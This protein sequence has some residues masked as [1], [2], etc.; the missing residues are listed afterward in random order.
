MM[1]SPSFTS[2]AQ[3]SVSSHDIRSISKVFTDCYGIGPWL[4]AVFGDDGSGRGNYITCDG[5]VLDG[6]PI[7]VYSILGGTC[8]LTSLELELLQPL[9]GKSVFSQYLDLRGGMPGFQHLCADDG[10]G[11]NQTRALLDSLGYR[12]EQ[13]CRIDSIELCVMRD[14]A[15]LLGCRLELHQRGESF[16][17][18]QIEP[19]FYPAGNTMSG[20]PTPIFSDCTGVTFVVKEIMDVLSV[21]QDAMHLGQ[22]TVEETHYSWLNHSYPVRK[23]VCSGMNIQLELLQPLSHD[24]FLSNHLNRWGPNALSLSMAAC[25]PR[26]EVYRRMK[27][28]SCGKQVRLSF[29]GCDRI[30][31]NHLELMGLY[32]EI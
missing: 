26:Q 19:E 15:P 16:R 31:C 2:F 3:V 4:F 30:F 9:N 12:D 7:G 32:L 21:L 8:R 29:D 28:A 22:W 13:F 6:E 27:T 24:G 17:Y 5:V 14:L 20:K 18:P 11:F 10:A 1:S 23:A 25:V